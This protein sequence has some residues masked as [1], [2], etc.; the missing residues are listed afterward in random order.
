MLPLMLGGNI[1]AYVKGRQH[2]PLVLG[3]LVLSFLAFLPMAWL[4]PFVVAELKV[5]GT[6]S[7]NP[8]WR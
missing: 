8:A 2:L 1:S 5:R 3:G 6:T 7:M 4:K